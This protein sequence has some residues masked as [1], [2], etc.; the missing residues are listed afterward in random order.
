MAEMSR[1]YRI[2]TET[3]DRKARFVKSRY[4][5]GSLRLTLYIHSFDNN[6]YRWYEPYADFTIDLNQ[7]ITDPYCAFINPGYGEMIYDW[8]ARKGLGYTTDVTVPYGIHF[9]E[10]V[11]FDKKFID[12]LVEFDGDHLP[13]ELGIKSKNVPSTVEVQ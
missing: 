7:S 4:Q 5:D 1:E 8:L 10:L 3:F 6:G 9:Y 13:A 11:K 2:N 12:R